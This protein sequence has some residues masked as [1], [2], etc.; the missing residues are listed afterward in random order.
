VLPKNKEGNMDNQYNG[1]IPLD[2]LKVVC[3]TFGDEEGNEIKLVFSLVLERGDGSVRITERWIKKHTGMS[4][5]EYD[6]A[7]CHLCDLGWVTYNDDNLTLN[8]DKIK[9]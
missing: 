2:I 5:E 6:K 1:C 9:E 3:K 7:I 4:T 8:F